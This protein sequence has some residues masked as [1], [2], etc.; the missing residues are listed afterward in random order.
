MADFQT[1]CGLLMRPSHVAACLADLGAKEP[2]AETREKAAKGAAFIASTKG[3]V[4]LAAG[5]ALYWARPRLPWI[6]AGVVL[7]GG[8]L[9]FGLR[10]PSSET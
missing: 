5:D 7:L 8:V 6:A 10:R 3:K 4:L 9:F 2:D 1:R